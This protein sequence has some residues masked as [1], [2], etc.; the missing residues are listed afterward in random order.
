MH[1]RAILLQTCPLYKQTVRVSPG[2]NLLK[3]WELKMVERGTVD[4]KGYFS[5][6]TFL[7]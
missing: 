1:L 7:G 3:G 5:A 6:L 4:P 2:D